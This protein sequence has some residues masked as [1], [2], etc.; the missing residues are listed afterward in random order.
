MSNKNTMAGVN[1]FESRKTAKKFIE[2][3]ETIVKGEGK[4]AGEKFNKTVSNLF[5]DKQ[6][7]EEGKYD[8]YKVTEEDLLGI[9]TSTFA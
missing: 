4:K 8:T 3:I 9:V 2:I 7:S 5:W 1:M 6:T